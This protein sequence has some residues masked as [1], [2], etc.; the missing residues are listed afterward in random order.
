LANLPYFFALGGAVGNPPCENES[1]DPGRARPTL[2]S[3]HNSVSDYLAAL[4]GLILLAIFVLIPPLGA[5]LIAKTIC[6]P[7]WKV[8]SPKAWTAGFVAIFVFSL[9]GLFVLEGMAAMITFGR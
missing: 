9:G 6:R 1:V 8:K 5:A 3:V 7:R 4:P 2:A